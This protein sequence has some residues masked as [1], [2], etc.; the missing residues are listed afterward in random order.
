VRLRTFAPIVAAGLA[1]LAASPASSQD[2]VVVAGE[3]YRGSG[4]SRM[5]N[6][7]EYRAEWTTP[8]RVPFLDPTRFAG[9]LTVEELGGGMATE[10]LRMRGRDGREYV[11]RSLD[12]NAERGL[13]EDLHDTFVE[14]IVQDLVSAKH[15]GAA[16]VV[17][18]LLEAVG[19]LHVTPTLYVMPDHPFLGE[20][21]QQFAGRLGQVEERPEDAQPDDEEPNAPRPPRGFADADRVVGT[22]LVTG[23]W[24]RHADQWR[25]AGFER[26][27]RWTW[28]AIP[29]DRDNAFSDYEGISS[30]TA[31]AFV[32]NLTRYGPRWRDLQGYLH[33][34]VEL[35]RRLLAELDRR[36][37]DSVTAFVRARVTDDVIARAVRQMP[38]E[39]Q[40][41]GA[42]E[43]TEAAPRWS[44][45]R[46][47]RW[48]CASSPRRT[49]ARRTI[50]AASSR[51]R[52]AR[53]A[54]TCTAATTGPRSRAR[55]RAASRCG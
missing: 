15:P 9:G 23:D 40:P 17:P 37:W 4:F 25:W 22:E 10:S 28:R 8:V 42:R 41:L 54:C 44:A 48:T 11:F 47:V 3:R 32:P 6:G 24:D 27:D 43:M 20:F 2:T 35:D 5:F 29:R 55:R 39:Y 1:S 31:R 19:V 36:A 38:A 53:S 45:W 14:W 52:R 46:T 33:L 51:R 21:R 26:G 18:P 13:P 16:H 50:A 34:P 30:A 7:D 12:K 49:R